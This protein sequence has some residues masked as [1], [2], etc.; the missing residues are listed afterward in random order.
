VSSPTILIAAGGTAGHVVPALA[1]ADALRGSGASVSFVGGGRAEAT[2]VPEA[3]YEFHRLNVVSLP[4]RSPLRALRA[5]A[6]DAGAFVRAFGLVGRLRPDVVMG[7][8]GYVAGPVGL[9]AALRRVP[10]VVT[11]IDSHLG[12]ANRLLAPLAVSVCSAMPLS[13]HAGGGEAGLGKFVVTGRP[14]A[15]VPTDRAAARARFGIPVDAVCVLVFGGSLGAR[16]INLAAVE[17]FASASFHVLHAAGERDLPSLEAPRAG[18]DLRGYVPD[19]MDALVAAD[20]VVARSGGS[21]FEIAAA[22]KPSVLIPYPHATGDH[23][24]ANA[25][26]LAD[27]GAAVLLPDGE[28]TAARLRSTV[29]SLLGDPERLAAMGAAA[30]ALARPDAA[31]S[32]ADTV[33]AAVRGR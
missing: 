5:V 17:G 14:V 25:R 33:L 28:L 18:Y 20:L 16:S 27:A 29:D 9:A 15:P 23:Q 11:E 6:V 26:Y 2:L 30:L 22:G 7:G 1:V 10:L 8:G 32:I 19:F 24:T 12:L 31:T 3:G 21:I 13:G 4:R